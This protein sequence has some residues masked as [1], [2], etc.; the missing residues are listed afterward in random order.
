MNQKDNYLQLDVGTITQVTGVILQGKPES[1]E[2]VT[3]LKILASNDTEMWVNVN[4]DEAIF[5]GNTD[6]DTELEI[7]FSD[8]TVGRYVRFLPQSFILGHQ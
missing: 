6:A 4:N 7:F 1:N 5:A 2:W 8:F 3:T